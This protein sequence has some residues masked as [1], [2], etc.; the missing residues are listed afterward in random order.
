VAEG[1]EAI[2]CDS[3][4]RSSNSPGDVQIDN[5]YLAGEKPGKTGRGAGNKVPFVLAV[6]TR[7]GK[8]LY[9]QVRRVKAFT[10][11]AIRDYATAQ[12]PARFHRRQ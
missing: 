3:A 8:P 4:A 12:H 1:A 10:R 6:A 9:T 5:A 2:E 7:D 11:E